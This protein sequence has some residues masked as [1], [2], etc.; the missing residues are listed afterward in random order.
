MNNIHYSSAFQ[1]SF[2][3]V[4]Y[5]SLDCKNKQADTVILVHGTPF[6]AYVWKK[7]I[8]K[9]SNNYH[10]VWLDLPGYGQSE[11]FAG[12]TVQLRDFAKAVAEFINHLQFSKPAHLVGHDFG[13]ATVLGAHLIEQVAVR[14]LTIINGVV[15]NPWGT[16]YA[17]LVNENEAVFASLPPHIHAATLKA[18]I[19]TAS[20]TILDEKTI[21]QLISPWLGDVGQAAYYRQIAQYDFQYTETL[22]QKYPSIKK[23]VLI[24]W[25]EEDQWV[26]VKMGKKLHQLIKQSTFVPLPDAGHL[27][28]LDC[29]NLLVNHLTDWLKHID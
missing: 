1:S 20:S 13:A 24:L 11:K 5:G 17:R 26:N 25:G 28:M 14:S 19:G 27:S 4:K 3:K 6:N 16:D 10:V 15:L 12:Q 23:P 21:Q 22:E 8:T 9:L 2:G 18:Q 7:V 29:P